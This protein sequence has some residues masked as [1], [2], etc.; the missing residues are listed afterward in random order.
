MKQCK[1]TQTQCCA[2]THKG[3]QCSK[4]TKSAK[5]SL[6]AIHEKVKPLRLMLVGDPEPWRIMGLASKACLYG[7]S[8]RKRLRT[9]CWD[10]PNNIDRNGFIY[11]YVC[12]ADKA[13]PYYKIGTTERSPEI[14]LKE[15]KGARL[16]RGFGVAHHKLAEHLVF[17]MLSDVRM[18]RHYNL[19]DKTYTSVWYTDGKAVTSEDQKRMDKG[20]GD[21]KRHIEW[22]SISGGEEYLFYVIEEVYKLVND[23]EHRH[24]KLKSYVD[25]RKTLGQ[26]PP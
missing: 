7:T 24:A 16:R 13:L 20:L 22:F 2:R 8:K 9:L 21:C 26:D 11:V 3:V 23:W 4:T 1:K 15:W 19:K 10:G 14:R 5:S 6:C 18:I 12:D 25:A 17:A